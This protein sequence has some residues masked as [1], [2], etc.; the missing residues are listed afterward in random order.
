MPLH[1]GLL[2][3]LASLLENSSEKLGSICCKITIGGV[4]R[5]KF[6]SR[7]LSASGPPV[8]DP[9]TI[10]SSGL[11]SYSSIA[12]ETSASLLGL[13]KLLRLRVFLNPDIFLD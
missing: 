5:G 8:L 12:N 2:I 11:S 9:I 4:S 6:L 13:I 7:T 1:K 3:C 10:R